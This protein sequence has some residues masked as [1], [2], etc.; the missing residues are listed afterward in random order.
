VFLL[1]PLIV[2]FNSC[3][4]YPNTGGAIG[5]AVKRMQMNGQV[6]EAE[7]SKRGKDKALVPSPHHKGISSD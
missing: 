2:G 3:D 5:L 4:N 7:S 1:P 6:V